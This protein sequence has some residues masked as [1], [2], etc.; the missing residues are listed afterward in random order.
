[1]QSI[2]NRKELEKL[3]ASD[4]GQQLLKTLRSKGVNPEALAAQ[5]AS[6]NTTAALAQLTAALRD[7]DIR[8]LLTQLGNTP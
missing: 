1:M 2:P 7:E 5:A 8:T 6:G 4:A 3:A